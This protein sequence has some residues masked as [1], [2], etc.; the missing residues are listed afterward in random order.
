MIDEAI[1]V[2]KLENRHPWN[3]Q[4]S[5]LRKAVQLGVEA[6]E[7]LKFIRDANPIVMS[8]LAYLKCLELLPSETEEGLNAN[9]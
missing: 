4:N 1:E 5:K 9:R 7:L 8:D 6:L 2:L 3:R